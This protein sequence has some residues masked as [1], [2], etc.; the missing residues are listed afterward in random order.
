MTNQRKRLMRWSQKR[1]RIRRRQPSTLTGLHCLKT[2]WRAP[3][4]GC[5]QWKRGT[6]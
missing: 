5:E 6:E 2:R 4:Y 1:H 3:P